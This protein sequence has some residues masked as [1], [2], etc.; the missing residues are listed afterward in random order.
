MAPLSHDRDS[1]SAIRKTSNRCG[2][3][4]RQLAVSHWALGATVGSSSAHLLLKAPVWFA[5]FH[6]FRNITAV[7][8]R[9]KIYEFYFLQKFTKALL[10]LRYRVSEGA[11]A[12]YKYYALLPKN[13]LLIRTIT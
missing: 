6:S 7:L 5:R 8:R 2:R 9:L 12:V 4:K 13:I 1:I 10:V 11:T 3:R